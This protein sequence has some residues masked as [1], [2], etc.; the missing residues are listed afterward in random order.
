MGLIDYQV[1]LGCLAVYCQRNKDT[2][3]CM[4]G[5][6][7]LEAANKWKKNRTQEPLGATIGG[8]ER[9]GLTTDTEKYLLKDS[10]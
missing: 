10:I 9:D 3:H 8:V 5:G 2:E 1:W 6:S 7:L 4:C